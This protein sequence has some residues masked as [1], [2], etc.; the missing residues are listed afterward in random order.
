M[1]DLPT[2]YAAIPTA[3][4]G[5][6]ELCKLAGVKETNRE[7]LLRKME[8]AGLLL[9]EDDFGKLYKYRV[10]RCAVC[11]HMSGFVTVPGGEQCLVCGC[12]PPVKVAQP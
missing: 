1:N 10:E 9:F 7:G 4:I 8:R 3:G 2:V 5:K 11:E 6:S 12:P